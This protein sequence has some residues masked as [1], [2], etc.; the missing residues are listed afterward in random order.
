RLDG[1]AADPARHAGH[2]A[3]VLL[4]FHL[5]EMQAQHRADLMTWLDTTAILVAIQRR[6]FGTLSYRAWCD[7]L[8]GELQASGALRVHGETVENA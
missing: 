6:F 5:M 3:R 8:I 7:R 2:A 4:K 1:L